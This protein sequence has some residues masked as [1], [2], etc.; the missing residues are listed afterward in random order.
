MAFLKG[1]VKPPLYIGS[2]KRK[3][4]A[5]SASALQARVWGWA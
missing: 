1:A 5:E 4:S 3:A 2:T